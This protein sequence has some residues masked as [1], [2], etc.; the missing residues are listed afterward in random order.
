[1]PLFIHK[2]DLKI[3]SKYCHVISQ[4][5]FLLVFAGTF[6]RHQVMFYLGFRNHVYALLLIFLLLLHVQ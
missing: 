4:P 5:M 2:L 3:S 1:M 6:P